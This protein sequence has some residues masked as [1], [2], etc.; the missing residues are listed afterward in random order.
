MG[1]ST[2]TL[3]QLQQ[4]MV[5]N[6]VGSQILRKFAIRRWASLASHHKIMSHGKQQNQKA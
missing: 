3:Q 4:K 2:A 1:K 6:L 5:E